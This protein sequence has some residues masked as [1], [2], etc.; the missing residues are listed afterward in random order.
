MF[1]IDK[2][3]YFSTRPWKLFPECLQVF[4]SAG[5]NSFRFPGSR[6][7]SAITGPRV[8]RYFFECRNLTH[9]R[10]CGS[11][12][13][14]GGNQRGLFSSTGEIIRD[15]GREKSGNCTSDEV[16]LAVAAAQLGN[17][18][19]V[20]WWSLAVTQSRLFSRWALHTSQTKQTPGDP[21]IHSRHNL[22]LV[23]R[24][25]GG[26]RRWTCSG[27][28]K[29]MAS[30]DLRWQYVRNVSRFSQPPTPRWGWQENYSYSMEPLC[31]HIV[32][33]VQ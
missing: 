6:V 26:G 15:G 33:K 1:W 30:L 7:K 16:T 20:T 5:R 17:K 9:A 28:D 31:P 3:A 19:A 14:K 22:N 23:S 4:A 24:V 32:I 2:A 10:L 27:L 12:V 13:Y 11:S 29:L 21:R 8:S 18:A 25:G